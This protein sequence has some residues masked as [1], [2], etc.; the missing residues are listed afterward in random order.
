MKH[1]IV[2]ALVTVAI[3]SSPA[4]ADYTLVL[5][6]GRRITV[7]NY[8]EETGMIKFPGLGG[9]IGISKDQ[10]EAIQQTGEQDR[11]GLLLPNAKPS[12][13]PA[14][15]REPTAQQ[16]ISIPPTRVK[17]PTAE[18]KLAEQRA[19]EEKEYVKRVEEITQRI[20]DERSRYGAETT[21]VTGPEPGFF[22]TDE[23]FRRHQDDL[24]SRLIDAQNNPAG[25]GNTGKGALTPPDN[26]V[27]PSY[28]E[29]ERQLSDLRYRLDQLEQER[30]RLIEEMKQKHF[31]AGSLFL[32]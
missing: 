2:T 5:K 21:G 28:T 24:M 19:K 26:R 9:E 3:F 4:S 20:R 27:P 15:T 1:Q 7:P 13:P 25:P 22:T 12:Q 32:E 11:T 30:K 31:D 23:A 6:N 10:I 16:K 29:R 8:R 18:E 17:E 14:V